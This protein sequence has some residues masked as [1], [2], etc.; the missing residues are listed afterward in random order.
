MEAPQ[1]SSD[2]SV[3]LWLYLIQ[4][5]LP[6]L[7]LADVLHAMRRGMAAHSDLF[8]AGVA[9]LWLLVGLGALLVMRARLLNKLKKPLLAFYAACFCFTFLEFAVHIAT[10]GARPVLWRPGTRLTYQPDPRILPGVTGASHF[11]VNEVGLRGPSLPRQRPVYK[12]VAVGGSTTLCLM[13]DDIEGWPGQL[14]QEMNL[15]QRALPVWVGNAGVN[16]HTAVHHLTLLRTL[17]FVQESNLV[18]LLPG[19]NDLQAT[20]SAEGASTQGFLQEDADEFHA[21]V[22]AGAD[23]PYPLYRRV[24][25]YRLARR[26]FDVLVQRSGAMERKSELDEVALRKQRASGIIVPLPNLDIGLREYGERLQRLGQQCKQLNIRC[27][28]LTQPALWR[29]DLPANEQGLLMFGWVG[30]KGKP[31]GYGSPGDLMRAMDSFNRVLLDT[32][33]Q[34]SLECFDLAAAAPKDSSAFY[35][36]VHFNQHGARIVA[37]ALADY[38]LRQPPFGQTANPTPVHMT[39][40]N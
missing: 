20:L 7:L 31:R 30:P 21:Y 16:G 1:Q 36:D 32:C 24:R 28:F 8:L 12:I 25:L 5:T 18:V 17:P 6:L 10:G 14:M 23:S 13:L 35:D 37:R 27:V 34:Y 40:P 26:A 4:L 9:G 11:S 29:L 3:L 38:L 33:R 39:G 22:L 2:T 15:R 19:I